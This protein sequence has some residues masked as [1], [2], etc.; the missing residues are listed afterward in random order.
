MHADTPRPTA[1]T[2]VVIAFGL[3]GVTT[4]T[5]G[6]YVFAGSYYSSGSLA[7]DLASASDPPPYGPAAPSVLPPSIY[8]TAR[9]ALVNGFPGFSI[10]G[11]FRIS[12][13]TLRGGQ[14]RD[15]T[16][17]GGGQVKFEDF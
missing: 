2:I 12:R 14:S 9:P 11:A 1:A 4:A 10:R 13:V 5:A 6:D 16:F 17:L 15:T 7:V 8:P 3:G